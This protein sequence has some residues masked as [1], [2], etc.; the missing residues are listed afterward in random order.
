MITPL[1]IKFTESTEAIVTQFGFKDLRS[2]VKDQAL[3]LLMAKIEKYDAENRIFEAKYNMSYKTF[4]KK[5]EA[6]QNEENFSH[7]DDY[8]DWR[9]ANEASERLRKQ[10]LELENA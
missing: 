5:I 1:D 3:L 2:F 9:F 8:L 10:K 6:L 4:H 7:E